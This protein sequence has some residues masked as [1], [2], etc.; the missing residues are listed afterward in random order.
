[1]LGPPISICPNNS[2]PF[3]KCGSMGHACSISEFRVPTP[4]REPVWVQY[5][6][7]STVHA[8]LDPTPSPD[9]NC[10]LT[11]QDPSSSHSGLLRA[12]QE[13]HARL[14]MDCSRSELEAVL[15]KKRKRGRVLNI[16]LTLL[17]CPEYGVRTAHG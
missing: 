2:F 4:Q 17:L 13:R 14:A 8:S 16:Y 12:T 5:H 3:G 9:C 11:K 6:R 1:M 7:Y 10:P 15:R